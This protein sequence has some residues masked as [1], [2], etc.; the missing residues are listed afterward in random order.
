[1]VPMLSS[2]E[3]ACDSFVGSSVRNL[4]FVIKLDIIHL[5]LHWAN[6]VAVHC[7][8]IDCLMY[9]N[10]HQ[11]TLSEP[12]ANVMLARHDCLNPLTNHHAGQS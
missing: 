12:L 9:H 1:M 7:W 10:D 5:D 11:V 8:D 6:Q 4:G 3:M 2:H